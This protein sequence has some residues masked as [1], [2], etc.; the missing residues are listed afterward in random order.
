MVYVCNTCGWEYDEDVD[1]LGP[2]VPKGSFTPGSNWE[3]IHDDF[4]CPLCG[5]SKDM[6]SE[7]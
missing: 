7:A 5:A 2:G 3:D 6:F 1:T 4:M